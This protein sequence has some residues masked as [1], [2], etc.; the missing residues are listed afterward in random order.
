MYYLALNLKDDSNDGWSL[1]EVPTLG[2]I[3]KKIM[4]GETKGGKIKIFKEID[5]EIVDPS[6]KQVNY[7]QLNEESKDNV[8]PLRRQI[9]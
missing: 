9:H 2:E 6:D 1:Q 7:R 5:I 4:S 8:E 3:K